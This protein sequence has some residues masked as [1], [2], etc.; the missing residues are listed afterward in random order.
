MTA[1]YPEPNRDI[2]PLNPPILPAR[3]HIRGVGWCTVDRVKI[4]DLVTGAGQQG[5]QFCRSV[6]LGQFGYASLYVPAAW[7]PEWANAGPRRQWLVTVQD[8]DEEETGD[9]E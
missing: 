5:L 4:E 2:I 1:P 6:F 7:G 8:T 3:V 9:D